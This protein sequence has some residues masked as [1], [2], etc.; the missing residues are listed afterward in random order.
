[1]KVS[2]CIPTYNQAAYLEA[3]VKSVISQT[4]LPDEIIISDDCSTDNTP[5][6][7]STLSKTNAL[8]K[9]LHQPINLGLTANSN[10]CLKAAD[11]ELVVRLSSDDLLLPGYIKTLASL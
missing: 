5:A 7:L 1:M 2:V 8:I 9:L 10:A 3:C 6:L 11:G 4:Q